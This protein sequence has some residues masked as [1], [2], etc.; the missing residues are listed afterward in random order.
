MSYFEFSYALQ[1]R[2]MGL[3]YASKAQTTQEQEHESGIQM[4]A[5]SEHKR[6]ADDAEKLAQN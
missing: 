3:D 1:M 5:T 2:D 4:G 6:G